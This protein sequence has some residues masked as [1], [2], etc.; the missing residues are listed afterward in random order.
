MST[1]PT[2]AT[3]LRRASPWPFIIVGLLGANIAF[4]FGAIMV[5]RSQNSAGVAS[6]QDDYDNKALAWDALQANLHRLGWTCSVSVHNGVLTVE[7][8]DKAGAPLV[9]TVTVRAYHN[10]YPD[11]AQT[12]TLSSDSSGA[13]TSR[14][15]A[16]QAGKHTF[17][18]TLTQGTDSALYERELFVENPT[19]NTEDRQGTSIK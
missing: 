16:S 15:D 11:R 13:F 7:A 3:P 17:I 14:F 6:V 5:S 19:P 12:L 9:G 10:K 4:V 2:S 18:V 1:I 8:K